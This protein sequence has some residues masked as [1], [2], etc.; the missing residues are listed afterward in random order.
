MYLAD[1][2]GHRPV[3]IEVI[4]DRSLL[5]AGA[6]S[7]QTL[8]GLVGLCLGSSSD[9]ARESSERN[10]LLVFGDIVEERKGFGEL[11]ASDGG[12]GLP[13]SQKGERNPE[14]NG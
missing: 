8:S 3:R 1:L 2:R 5:R 14:V 7:Q 13:A 11:E 4:Q 9:T 12:G 10:T 6:A